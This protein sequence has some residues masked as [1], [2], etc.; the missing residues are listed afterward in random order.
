M[1]RAHTRQICARI[2][3]TCWPIPAL[4]QCYKSSYS[5]W[6]SSCHSTR[7]FKWSVWV[8]VFQFPPVAVLALLDPLSHVHL[9]SF[10]VFLKASLF[11]FKNVFDAFGDPGFVVGDKACRLCWNNISHS[12]RSWCT[13]YNS[14]RSTVS[15]RCCTK[16]ALQNLISVLW[17]F[18]LV[19]CC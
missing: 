4:P 2:N 6:S 13:L 8:F 12:R 15:S 16:A 10:C 7:H 11:S 17:T 5:Q 3:S 9:L 1:N 19:K 14:L 18:P